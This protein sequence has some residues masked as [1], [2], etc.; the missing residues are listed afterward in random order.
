[1]TQQRQRS[2]REPPP[3]V[4]NNKKGTH[5]LPRQ[6]MKLLG[7]LLYPPTM[8][9]IGLKVPLMSMATGTNLLAF[10][11][12]DRDRRYF[13]ATASSLSPGHPCIRKRWKQV[14]KTP[15]ARPTLTEVIVAQPEACEHY[16]YYNGCVAKFQPTTDR[17][18]CSQSI[19][20]DAVSTHTHSGSFIKCFAS[21]VVEHNA[22]IS[23]SPI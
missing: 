21:L 3:P 13:I 6:K 20:E 11:W 18:F 2:V 9:A 8:V 14:D 5:P 22:N 12:V 15:N 7:P 19:E 4:L 23:Q 16:Y 17:P 1:M 10:V